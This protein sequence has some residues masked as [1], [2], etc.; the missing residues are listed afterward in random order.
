MLGLESLLMQVGLVE[1]I[2]AT[3]GTFAILISTAFGI[4]TY[5]ITNY[6]KVRREELTERDK[7]IM[8]TFKGV[9]MIAQKSAETIGSNKELIK[10]LYEANLTPEQR[11]DIESKITP[12]LEQTDE[13]LKKANEQAA[14]IKAIAVKIFGTAGDVDQDPT[15]PREALGIS[16]KL[17]SA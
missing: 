14:L 8:E 7:Q 5:V 4:A 3:V 9:Q 11:I 15:I 16:Q 10:V 12:L 1:Q 13:R 2:N 17:R 6:R